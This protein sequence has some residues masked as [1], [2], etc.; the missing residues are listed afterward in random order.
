MRAPVHYSRVHAQCIELL[1][2]TA[3]S[4]TCELMQ[5]HAK[6]V[7]SDLLSQPHEPPPQPPAAVKL[8]PLALVMLRSQ[9]AS[10]SVGWMPITESKSDFLAPSRRAKANP[11]VNSP[12]K[13]RT[14][15]SHTCVNVSA[16]ESISYHTHLSEQHDARGKE[17]LRDVKLQLQAILLRIETALPQ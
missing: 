8:S 12:V 13:H 3:T 9:K 11:C 17:Q 10:A 15:E 1:C 16:V 14:T 5:R 6:P 7:L 4:G 2:L